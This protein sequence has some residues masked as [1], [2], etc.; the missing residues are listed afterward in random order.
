MPGVKVQGF[1]SATLVN[2]S[3]AAL[4][5]YYIRMRISLTEEE[6]NK[7]SEPYY[8]RFMTRAGKMAH[9]PIDKYRYVDECVLETC[10]YYDE[11]DAFPV[12]TPMVCFDR[13]DRGSDDEVE[14]DYFSRPLE[15]YSRLYMGA[16]AVRDRLESKFPDCR[17]TE[18]GFM[19]NDLMLFLRLRGNF[20][21][22]ASSDT[23]VP[24]FTWDRRFLVP[25][26]GAKPVLGRGF[27]LALPTTNGGAELF[28]YERDRV[29]LF[30]SINQVVQYAE[31]H[32]YKGG[33][34]RIDPKRHLLSVD[35]IQASDTLS[36]QLRRLARAV[37]YLKVATYS[38]VPHSVKVFVDLQWRCE[39]RSLG[40]VHPKQN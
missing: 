20:I 13:E 26:E 22:A 36:M 1:W 21:V 39:V 3:S 32:V 27:K 19:G 35:I 34:L 11:P 14:D 8:V 24:I 40:F 16:A 5:R 10:F 15:M 38:R 30:S 23:S 17:P 29:Q 7:K 2:A 4:K 28:W 37:P 18:V 9:V 33:E 6:Y 25:M 31:A 12:Q